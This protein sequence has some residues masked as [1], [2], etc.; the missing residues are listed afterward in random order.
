[1]NVKN[2]ERLQRL[3]ESLPLMV[4]TCDSEG[5][6]DYLSPQWVEYTGIPDT[7]QHGHG[8]LGQV[9]PND[10]DHTITEWT[11][12]A[13]SRSHFNTEFR[14]RRH[15]GVYRWF[16]ALAKPSLDE[17]GN[18]LA[19]YGSNTDIQD[20]VDIR[21]ELAALNRELEQRVELRAQ[22]LEQTN[23]TLISVT[24]E[25]RNAQRIAGVGSWSM[26]PATGDVHWSAELYRIFG[27]PA[28]QTVP[29]FEDQECFFPAREWE[30]ISEAVTQLLD[31]AQSY[32]LDVQ[33]LSADGDIRWAVARGEPI[34]NKSGKVVRLVGTLQEV[35]AQREAE[36]ASRQSERLLKEFIIHAPAPIA[37]LD[38][39]LRHI[40]A[41]QRWLADYRLQEAV[42]RGLSLYEIFP[43]VPQR[44]RE[45]HQL[46]LQGEVHRCK[47][48]PFEVWSGH[49]EWLQ[50]EVRPWH[51]DDGAVGGM[52]IFVQLVTKRKQLELELEEQKNELKRSNLDLEHFAYAASH[53][54]QEPL[55]AIS[56]CA[57]ALQLSAQGKLD[58]FDNEL[59]EHVV[60][61]ASRMRIL[62]L[63]LL[64]Y[65]R[66]DS[67][68][69]KHETFDLQS[70]VDAG[71]EGLSVALEESSGTVSCGPLPRVQGDRAQLTRLLQNLLSNALKY[72][73][74]REPQL[75][76]SA[77]RQGDLWE[78]AVQDNGLGMDS[79]YF[80]KI[81]L[82]FQRLHTRGE[83][84]GTGIG[85]A[86]CKKIVER[87]GGTIWVESTLDVGSTFFFTLPA[88]SE[89]PSADDELN[90][91]AT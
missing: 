50:W 33:I 79:D 90:P 53:D 42:D 91:Q 78:I 1:M 9:H 31:H 23:E 70:V 57:Q 35:T 38:R 24:K 61:G 52:L 74:D 88:L 66:V 25:L 27:L 54:L 39:D 85:L 3:A 19:W 49:V 76:I 20:V 36:I 69:A 67:H 6:C 34:F 81:F 58:E 10:R 4:W 51:H 56:G 45:V 13:E 72:R 43:H 2:E 65:A 71:L 59:I 40:V 48:D 68:S 73:G 44:W 55:R 37:M 84:P 22:Q 47:E 77:E 14:V 80:D 30:R 28:N 46:V 89:D 7:E 32:E 15:D 83:Y 29:K 17:D 41:S 86:L 21:E 63:D 75:K 82:I 8:W 5:Y 60:D 26:D 62:I 64:E 11:K 12:A 16:K 18:F 87:H